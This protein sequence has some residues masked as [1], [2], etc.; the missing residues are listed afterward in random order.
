MTL[1]WEKLGTVAPGA[2]LFSF[3]RKKCTSS[4]VLCVAD[5]LG[6]ADNHL[7]QSPFSSPGFHGRRRSGQGAGALLCWEHSC[8]AWSP[9]MH[10]VACQ[11][12]E[13]CHQEVVLSSGDHSAVVVLDT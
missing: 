2:P 1:K 3:A 4:Q 8:P 6:E 9:R 10:A 11:A 7:K 12:A 5:R 13:I